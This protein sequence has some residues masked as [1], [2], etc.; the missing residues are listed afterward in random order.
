MMRAYGV[1][2]VLAI[3]LATAPARAQSSEAKAAAEASFEEA[4]QLVLAG[5]FAEACPKL[6]A[7]QRL[8]PAPGTELNLADCYEKTDRFASAWGMFQQAADDERRAGDA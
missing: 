6:E 8:D 7:S 2:A 3:G 5:H 4:R 1:S